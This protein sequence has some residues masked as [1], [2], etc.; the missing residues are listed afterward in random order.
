MWQVDEGP[1]TG[2]RTD[3]PSP[4]S[5]AALEQRLRG[6]QEELAEIQRLI[7]RRVTPERGDKEE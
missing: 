6:L 1:V 2:T 7:Y 3:S 5:L 4:S